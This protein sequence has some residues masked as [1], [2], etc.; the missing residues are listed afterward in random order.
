MRVDLVNL[1]CMSCIQC[2]PWEVPFGVAVEK[3]EVK[4]AVALSTLNWWWKDFSTPSALANQRQ[5]GEL[6]IEAILKIAAR[7]S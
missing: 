5:R 2:E 4:L 6:H 3:R 1:T 7:E